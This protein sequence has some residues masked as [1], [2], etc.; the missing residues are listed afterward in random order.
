MNS[1]DARRVN[2]DLEQ[3]LGIGQ[4]RHQRRVKL[5]GEVRLERAG[6]VSLEVIRANRCLDYREKTPQDAVL[7]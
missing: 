4:P 5:E 2:I 7:V 1:L 6:D 3:G